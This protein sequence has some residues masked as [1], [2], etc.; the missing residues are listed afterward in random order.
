VQIAAEKALAAANKARK[1][2]ITTATGKKASAIQPIQSDGSESD[3]PGE[4][5]THL[6]PNPPPDANS[7]GNTLSD[8]G[9]VVPQPYQRP[10]PRPRRRV[11]D[12]T[13]IP[14]GGGQ[15]EHAELNTNTTVE[16]EMNIR[17]NPR[18]NAAKR[19]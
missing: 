9:D 4:T 12:E 2:Q 8:G 3:S 18:R 13:N 6:A 14:T 7:P 5:T 10:R 16:S 1:K 19:P 11:A 15:T 17:R